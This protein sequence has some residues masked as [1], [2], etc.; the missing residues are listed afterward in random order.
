MFKNNLHKTRAVNV[1]EQLAESG[2][3]YKQLMVPIN[4]L[5]RTPAVNVPEQLD[6]AGSN[7]Y[8]LG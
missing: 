1:L 7:P 3:K 4:L 6:R 2:Y 8:E 5:L